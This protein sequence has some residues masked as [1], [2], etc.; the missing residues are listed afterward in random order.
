M[1]EVAAEANR[2]DV[3]RLLIE[4][5]ADPNVYV[6]AATPKQDADD[7]DDNDDWFYSPK[8]TINPPLSGAAMAGRLECVKVLVDKVKVWIDEP[9][10]C[11][12][13]TALLYVMGYGHVE[14]LA[15]QRRF[16]RDPCRPRRHGRTGAE[17]GQCRSR[18]SRHRERA[19]ESIGY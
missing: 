4:L 14:V 13:S 18:E 10:V 6:A 15:V 1:Y 3:I 7:E 8:F 11:G 2:A 5:G 9:D 12:G 17:N 16:A 19:V